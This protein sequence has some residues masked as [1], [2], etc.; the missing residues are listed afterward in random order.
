MEKHT[1]P[2][3]NKPSRH[4]SNKKNGFLHVLRIVMYMLRRRSDKKNQAA[5]DDV[6][7]KGLWKRL[8]SSMRPLH[9]HHQLPYHHHHS[10][11][12]H[13]TVLEV[14]SSPNAC[15][16]HDVPP[17]PASSS[18][19]GTKSRYASAV[20]LQALDK[21]DQGENIEVVIE[22]GCFNYYEEIEA[23]EMIDEKAEEFIA[24]FYAQMKIQRLESMRYRLGNE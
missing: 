16:Y 9:H 23:D 13:Q 24:N 22:E 11:A 1:I 21:P 5:A 17:S 6:A 14:P 18:S 15:S 4:L 2:T 7:S 8:V 19:D 10:P 3:H 20:D 12:N